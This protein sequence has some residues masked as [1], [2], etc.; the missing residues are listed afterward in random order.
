MGD[1]DY[2]HMCRM[3][4][5]QIGHNDSEDGCPVC[6]A[7]RDAQHIKDSLINLLYDWARDGVSLPVRVVLGL[8]QLADRPAEGK[9][10]ATV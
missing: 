8:K 4:H 2:A 7:L 1:R 3:D 5:V 9:S 6:A 10:D